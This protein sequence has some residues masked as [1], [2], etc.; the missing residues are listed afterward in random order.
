MPRQV[1]QQGQGALSDMYDI[2]PSFSLPRLTARTLK[3]WLAPD[4]HRDFFNLFGLKVLGNIDELAVLKSILE[5]LA[6]AAQATLGVV[7]MIEEEKNRL[8]FYHAIG[9]SFSAHAIRNVAW[10]LSRQQQHFTQGLD[11]TYIFD[12]QSFARRQDF[13]FEKSL[14]FKSLI[15]QPLGVEGQILG[16]VLLG[17]Q[18]HTG[19]F[20]GPDIERLVE[21]ALL[22]GPEL[23]RIWLYRE[24]HGMIMNMMR[25]FISTIEAKDRYTCGHSER[26][27]AYCLKIGQRL[28]WS[29]ERLDI[30]RISAM[31]HDIGKIGVPE[32][33]LLK[34]DK[35]TEEEYAIIKSH[36]LNGTRIIEQVPQFQNALPGI[37]CHHERFD[38]NGY[39]LGLGG[40]EIPEFGRLLAV[41]DAYD[42]MTG[43]RPYRQKLSHSQ[44]VAEL[45]QNR[46]KQFD[47]QLVDVFL[48]ACQQGVWK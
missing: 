3:E 24:L 45:R 31:L 17:N 40:K 27:T 20:S 10:S 43:E 41:T 33:I 42:A 5:R 7:L 25:A 18:R 22:I 36:P 11:K 19:D 15:F 47:P 39:P 26:V 30:L 2:H 37:L 34:P 35:L 29:Q 44:A 1:R 48:E 23:E 8:A 12:C 13:N 9:M 16:A 38:G 14:G 46:G 4:G 28:G 6:R 32:S 21:E